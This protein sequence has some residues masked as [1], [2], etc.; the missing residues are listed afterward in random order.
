RLIEGPLMDPA[1]AGRFLTTTTPGP[2][3]HGLTLGEMARYVNHRLLRPARLTVVPMRGWT[4]E[5]TWADTGRPW[6]AP[7]PNLRSAEA[8]LA[9]P[10]LA[11]LEGTNVSEGRGT[12]APFLLLGAPWL[13]PDRAALEV[14]APGF[15]VEAAS[16]TPR[17]LEGVRSPRYAGVP[18]RGLR[19]RVGDG[20]NAR[21]YALGLALLSWLRGEPGFRF[22]DGGQRLDRLLGTSRVRRA[23]ERGEGPDSI[24]R[25]DAAGIETFRTARRDFLLY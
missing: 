2:L 23:L 10:G 21:P 19:V 1:F 6:I 16:F 22:L 18:C 20:A 25:G 14:N 5:M 12:D 7:S 15:L 8:A 9:Y 11:L 17:A 4:R 13:A 24:E 3:V